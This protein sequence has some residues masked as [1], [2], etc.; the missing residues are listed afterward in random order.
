ML[1]NYWEE[2]NMTPDI[3][4]FHEQVCDKVG[5]P[6]WIKDIKCPFCGIEL[7]S[8]SI[9]NVRLCLN[10]RNFGDIAVEVFCNECKKMDTLYFRTEVKNVHD[11]WDFL[12]GGLDPKKDP[13]LEEKM[14]SLGYNNVFEQMLL[15]DKGNKGVK[16]GDL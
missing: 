6:K 15:G 10:A 11:F 2:Q 3:N 1:N 5:L 9:R 16:D 14:F 13:V 8:R 4:E 7:P 12:R